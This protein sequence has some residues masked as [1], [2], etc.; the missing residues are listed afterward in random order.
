M[1]KSPVYFGVFWGF[2]GKMEKFLQTLKEN[3][4]LNQQL[5]DSA[6]A[7]AE[8]RQTF[9][10]HGFELVDKN[11][12]AKVYELYATYHR[13]KLVNLSKKDIH[14]DIIHL[15]DLNLATKTRCI[16]IDRV[17][18]NIIVAMA[19]PKDLKVI[20]MVRFGTGFVVKAVLAPESQINEAMSKY[21]AGSDK[22]TDF[23]ALGSDQSVEL[24]E[25]ARQ[26]IGDAKSNEGPIIDFIN[27]V[28]FQCLDQ[29]A[30]DVHFEAYES[31]LRVRLR[32]DGALYEIAEPPS[33]YRLSM[34]SRLK[35]MAGMDIAEK[36]KPQDGGI[37]VK[38]RNKPID[39]RVSSLPT[40]HGEKIVLRILDSSSLEVDMTKLGFEEDDLD[41]FKTAIHRPFGMVL[42]TGPTGS[43]KTTTLYSALEDLNN[44]SQNLMT[45]EDPVEFNLEGIN[46]VQI[47]EAAGLFF[48]DALKA[49]LRQDPD[50]IM[51]GEIRDLETG[52]I[53]IKA[54]L[55][56]HMVLSTLHTNSAADTIV[57]LIN[58]GL[59]PFNLI[60]AL[61]CI[62]AQR[63]MRKICEKCRVVDNGVTPEVLVQLGIPEQFTGQVKAYKGQG[64]DS[65][66]KTGYKGRVAVHEVL[67]MEDTIRDSIMKGGNAMDFRSIAMGSGMRTLRQNALNKMVRG[68]SDAREVVKN[69]AND[70]D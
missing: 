4:G 31:R 19:N 61:N 37:R 69:T 40:I 55:T 16:P 60:S 47:N 54:A 59:A 48:N 44:D 52:E 67:I 66:G 34:I 68:I 33:N 7:A 20:D 63:L 39:F 50:I 27:K 8:K 53:A 45:A 9:F 5:I 42:V 58:M 36:R 23:E 38:L 56:G 26:V 32:I 6:L 35:I 29:G 17:G 62:V 18:N 46:Q 22:I 1:P 25:N 64:C 70:T 3:L 65:C 12:A 13:I 14:R 15:L 30:S 57:R 21:Y 10:I 24:M 41:R 11:I 49:F 43:G 51:V 28:L 2:I